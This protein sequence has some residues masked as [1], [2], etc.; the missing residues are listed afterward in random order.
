MVFR[1]PNIKE[2]S[3]FEPCVYLTYLG[4]YSHLE[5]VKCT[6]NSIFKWPELPG[7]CIYALEICLADASVNFVKWSKNLNFISKFEL[8]KIELNLKNGVQ[9]SK[10]ER[11]FNFEPCV[12]LAYFSS[13]GH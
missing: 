3:I 9:T 1:C 4:S 10:Y 8:K 11:L 5:I 2:F 13:Y 12:Y 6:K 7:K